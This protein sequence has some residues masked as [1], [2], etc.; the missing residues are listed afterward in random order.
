MKVNGSGASSALRGVRSIKKHLPRERQDVS[1]RHEGE[2]EAQRGP[3][4]CRGDMRGSSGT[5][6]G[7]T[8]PTKDNQ[9]V[10]ARS[11]SRPLWR[12][13][14][15][16][17]Y[18]KRNMRSNP[19]R[20]FS[21]AHQSQSGGVHALVQPLHVRGG[22]GIAAQRLGAFGSRTRRVPVGERTSASDNS[23]IRVMAARCQ[24]LRDRRWISSGRLWNHRRG[25][26][27]HQLQ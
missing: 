7:D 17:E 20:P 1:T 9:L 26:D 11:T 22:A 24:R 3:S 16:S 19:S 13:T 4:L 23:N 2:R 18:S 15:S 21:P 25:A 8:G 27:G 12:S 6:L 10:A 14:P 5:T